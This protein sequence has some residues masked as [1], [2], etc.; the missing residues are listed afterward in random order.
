MAIPWGL[1]GRMGLL[2]MR[3]CIRIW[4]FSKKFSKSYQLW[5]NRLTRRRKSRCFLHRGGLDC[6]ALQLTDSGYPCGTF[7]RFSLLLFS[8]QNLV[9][10]EF[11]IFS[12]L[13]FFKMCCRQVF[14]TWF[15]QLHIVD[16]KFSRS[17]VICFLTT[18]NFIFGKLKFCSFEKVFQ[19]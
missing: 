3:N 18:W 10:S 2:T 6:A 19:D 11:V 4:D 7:W 9:K 13:F 15:G 1:R 14:D 8:S 16:R 17:H 5:S 12:R